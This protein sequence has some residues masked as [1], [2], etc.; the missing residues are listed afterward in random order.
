MKIAD[1]FVL[2]CIGFILGGVS[3]ILIDNF[4]VTNIDHARL[5]ISKEDILKMK[6]N[7][8]KQDFTNNDYCEKQYKENM[9]LYGLFSIEAKK[10][11][12]AE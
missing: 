10:Q 4:Y 12:G 3:V 6:E 5:N 9:L 2:L 1:I 7:C 11:K 8:I